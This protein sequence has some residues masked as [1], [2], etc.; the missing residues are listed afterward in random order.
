MMSRNDHLAEIVLKSMPVYK[1]WPKTGI[2]YL[3]TVD[4][5]TNPKA[6]RSSI[7][8]YYEI[9]AS[10]DVDHVFAADARGFIW[11][12]PIAYRLGIPLHVVRKKGKMPG[13]LLSKD[14][15]LDYGTDT[16]EV[17]NIHLNQGTALIVDDVLAT[18]ST[19]LAICELVHQLGIAYE[20]MFVACLLNLDF[21]GGKQKLKNLGVHVETLVEKTYI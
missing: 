4:I 9:G 21:L 19:A 18:G 17:C 14:Y 5:C 6:F 1:D 20:K 2:N 13:E 3:N 10:R 11:G 16:L 12:S 8:F 7:D 15:E